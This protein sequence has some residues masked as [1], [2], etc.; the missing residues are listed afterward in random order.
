MTETPQETIT[1]FLEQN[2]E[3]GY[4]IEDPK[5][6]I[7]TTD[8]W[9]LYSIWS[10]ETGR[11]RLTRRVYGSTIGRLRRYPVVREGTMIRGRSGLRAAWVKPGNEW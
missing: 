6:R 8:L 11:P 1:R 4:L 2:L 9:N 10:Q 5:G 3:S 7:A